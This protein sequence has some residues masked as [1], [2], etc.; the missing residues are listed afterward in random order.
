GEFE[1]GIAG[2]AHRQRARI[3]RRRPAGRYELRRM[4][5]GVPRLRRK[6]GVGVDGVAPFGP[7][8]EKR[9]R[10]RSS[11]SQQS[12]RHD[13]ALERAVGLFPP[14]LLFHDGRRSSNGYRT[15]CTQA[16]LLF[17]PRSGTVARERSGGLMPQSSRTAN[18]SD[19]I[20]FWSSFEPADRAG[21]VE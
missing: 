8:I 16:P 17:L 18:L 14:Y 1:I 10:Q 19:M 7:R 2:P 4:A 5:G 3:T 13:E 6:D 9:A 15:H 12:G 21:E 11:G 20:L